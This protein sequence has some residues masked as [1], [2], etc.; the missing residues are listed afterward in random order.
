MDSFEGLLYY[1]RVL[2][3]LGSIMFLFLLVAM[4][5]YIFQKRPVKGLLYF[6]V[7]PVLMIGWPGIEKISYGDLLVELDKKADEVK[8][9][10]TNPTARRELEQAIRDIEDRAPAR[11]SSFVRMAEAQAALGD[12]SRVIRTTNQALKIDPNNLRALDL[13]SRFR[14][15]P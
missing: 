5:I 15:I 3:V 9:N 2:L 4:I 11:A 10:P 14:R 6:F 12:T 7:I 13:N 1:E 8:N